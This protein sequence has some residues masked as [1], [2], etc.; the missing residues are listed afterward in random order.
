MIRVFER[1]IQVHQLLSVRGGRTRMIGLKGSTFSAGAVSLRAEKPLLVVVIYL[2]YIIHW[3]N[4]EKVNRCRFLFIFMQL[5]ITIVLKYSHSGT[6]SG[7]P[8]IYLI[9]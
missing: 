7:S 1:Y 6:C 4:I 5:S 9:S 2:N 3:L 8:Y